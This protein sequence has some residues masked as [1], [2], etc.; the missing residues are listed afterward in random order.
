MCGT[1]KCW[2]DVL[3]EVSTCVCARSS[4]AG[5]RTYALSFDYANGLKY[6][7]VDHSMGKGTV[8]ILYAEHA[9]DSLDVSLEMWGLTNADIAPATGDVRDRSLLAPL[10]CKR[11]CS[12]RLC[13]CWMQN[14]LKQ[15]VSFSNTTNVLDVNIHTGLFA[16]TSPCLSATLMITLPKDIFDII[17][18]S[19]TNYAMV[20]RFRLSTICLFVVLTQKRRLLSEQ[21][22]LACP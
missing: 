3:T 2:V 4:D 13:V 5:H 19:N 8:T 12:P 18:S 14:P 16:S 7:N 6:V 20:R 21:L 22:D 1:Q 10:L 17:L 9:K 11:N 15:A